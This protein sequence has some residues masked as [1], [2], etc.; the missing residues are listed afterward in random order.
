MKKCFFSSVAF[1][2]SICMVCSSVFAVEPNTNEATDKRITE[3]SFILES[4]NRQQ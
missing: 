4:R 1:L 3:T 2:L